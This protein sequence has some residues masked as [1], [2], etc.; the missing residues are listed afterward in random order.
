[1]LTVHDFISQLHTILCACEFWHNAHILGIDLIGLR[2]ET[3][4]IHFKMQNGKC[5][6][7]TFTEIPLED[8]NK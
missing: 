1:M 8:F 3:R 2:Q 6:R 5:Y 4:A 7:A